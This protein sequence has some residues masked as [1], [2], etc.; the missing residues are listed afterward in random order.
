MSIAATSA[1]TIGQ[2]LPW[3]NTTLDYMEQLVTKIPDELLEWRP[4]DPNGH[5]CFSLAELAMHS[6]DARLMFARQL[7]ASEDKAGYFS[8]ADD[9]TADEDNI[10]RFRP[11]GGLPAILDALKAARAEL[12][13][14]LELPVDQLHQPTEGTRKVYDEFLAKL[15]EKGEDTTALELR[16]P[17]TI[18]RVLF[19]VCTHEAGHRGALQTLLRL[20][21]VDAR[22][23]H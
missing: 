19:A 1:V 11:H 5:F 22:G 9:D 14:W 15:R 23:E 17:A 8:V 13:P 12:Q 3:V 4:V 2:H 21:G 6:A 20:N 16:G 10:W 18:N 7:S